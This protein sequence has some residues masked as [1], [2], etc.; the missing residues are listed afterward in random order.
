MKK[1]SFYTIGSLIILLICAFVFVILPAITGR[2]GN[3][4]QLPA[5]GKYEKTEIRYE[6]GSDMAEFVSNYGRMLQ[7][8]GQQIDSSTYYYIFNSAFNSAVAQAAYKSEVKKAGYKV[9]KSAVNRAMVPYF[10]DETGK[11]SSKLYKQTPASTIQDIQKQVENSLTATVFYEDLFGSESSIVGS[12]PL[13]GLKV[14]DNELDF[15]TNFGD[16]KRGFDVAIFNLSDYPEEKVIE[17]G[18][19]NLGKFTKY[20]MSM[21]TCVEKATAEKILKRINNGEIT[22]ID[23]ISE[24]S[25]KNYTNSEGKLNN[26]YQYQLE[27]ILVNKADIDT[28]AKLA[29][30]T[31]SDLIETN[32]GYSIIHVDGEAVKADLSNS[33]TVSAV[34]SYIRAF[35]NSIIENYY[36]EKANN[37]KTEAAVS[38]FED[39]CEKSGITKAEIDP[40]PLN[41]GNVSIASSLSA[42][43][44]GI[45]A[46]STN[47]N[48]LKTAF[49]L[50]MNEVSSPIVVGNTVVVLKY[51]IEV[52]NSNLDD[53]QDAYFTDIENFDSETL[54]AAILDSPKLENNFTTV[55]FQ[56]F[57]N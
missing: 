7:S 15:L 24:Y 20:D 36:I 27:N 47:E 9:P 55:Y 19:E 1:N 2:Q 54:Q 52:A 14:S 6:Q 34:S 29:V 57:M 8:Y 56:Y 43:D 23:A 13:Y 22:F 49:S 3:Q 38:S 26:S 35:E 31:N 41:Y 17:F 50:S 39:A 16:A 10:Y 32:A 48:F 45:G 18:K 21:L 11:Y 30:G 53:S 42:T 28:L 46:A 4:E 51:T 12:N 25:E 33:D 37:L 40:F 5:F 44:L